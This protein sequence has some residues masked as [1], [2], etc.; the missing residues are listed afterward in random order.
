MWQLVKSELKYYQVAFTAPIFFSILFQAM[1]FFVLYITSD[2]EIQSGHSKN[3]ES[4]DG[5]YSLVIFI[6]IF[7]IWSTRFKE[8]RER[9]LAL[10]PLTAKQI[11][12]SRF[13]FAVIPMTILVFYFLVLHLI[14]NFVWNISL[15]LPLLQLGIIFILFAGFI[16]ARD[17]WFSH[18]N[19]GKRTQAAFVS[20]LIIQ[21][22]AVVLFVTLSESYEGSVS[23]LGKAF[24]HYV[25]IIFYLLGLVIMVTTIFSFLKRKSYLS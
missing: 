6:S 24:Y 11:A 15:S 1:G 16:R 12:L 14:I 20:V 17:D 3:I 5:F 9:F 18:W 19:F 10:L 22:I 21:I 2:L 8:K 4:W 7:S 25:K 23:S 13:W